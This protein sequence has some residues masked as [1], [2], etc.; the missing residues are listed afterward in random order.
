MGKGRDP[1]PPPSEL[2]SV[3]G[4]LIRERL[5]PA[6]GMA[7]CCESADPAASFMVP[8]INSCLQIDQVRVRYPSRTIHPDPA[9]LAGLMAAQPSATP[10]DFLNTS[11]SSPNAVI[12]GV[13]RGAA[14][15][16]QRFTLRKWWCIQAPLKE[17]LLDQG[18]PKTRLVERLPEPWPPAPRQRRPLFQPRQHA[19]SR[20][21]CH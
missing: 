16:G 9:F 17:I 14:K 2:A 12:N 19:G 4:S 13:I 3:D 21:D 5:P 11:R 6:K 18:S 10:E 1:P 15:R 20:P 8:F 7:E